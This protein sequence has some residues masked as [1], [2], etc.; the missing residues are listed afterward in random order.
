[1]THP[2]NRKISFFLVLIL[3]FQLCVGCSPETAFHT[4]DFQEKQISERIVGENLITEELLST[5][6][7]TEHLIPEEGIYEYAISEEV[8]C[9]T[10]VIELTVGVQTEEEI[11]AQLPLELEE[12]NINWPGVIGKFAA[13]TTIILVVGIINYFT[14]GST[15]FVFGSSAGITKDAIVGGAVGA[16][17]GTLFN[18]ISEEKLPPE[19]I[20]KY[21]IEGFADGYMWGAIASVT[22]IAGE[23]FNR[24]KS[25][26][27]ASGGKAVIKPDGRVFDEAGKQIGHAF[28]ENKGFWYLLDDASNTVQVFDK[29]GKFVA[30]SAV[31]VSVH[32][33]PKNSMLRLGTAA[34]SPICYTDDLGHTLRMGNDLIPDGHYRLNGYDY[35]TDHL[36]RITKVSFEELKLRPDGQP[37][38]LIQNHID[39]IGKGYALP[40]DDRGHLIA[41]LFDGD[42]SLANLVPMDYSINRGEVK[43]IELQWKHC[44]ETGGHVRG[45]IEVSYPGES[46]RPDHYNYTYDMGNGMIDTLI[47]NMP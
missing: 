2:F 5:S 30:D 20:K 40:S 18:G 22:K 3:L 10:Y 13:G 23:N 39:E 46:F 24:L 11:L 21:A 12:Y 29:A 36:G 8:I 41:D 47:S 38:K 19:G 9:E 25:F 35:Y 31:L 7:I 14:K 17:L 45:S 15:Y 43:A 6:Y 16:A 1:M 33:L 34:Q 27:L 28:Y 42:S 26:K 32:S 4:G 44:L 37:R